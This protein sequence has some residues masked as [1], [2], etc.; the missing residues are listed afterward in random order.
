MCIHK[1]KG[2]WKVGE[3]HPVIFLGLVGTSPLTYTRIERCVKCGKRQKDR[4][5]AR[6]YSYCA[7]AAAA[8]GA[9]LVN[10]CYAGPIGFPVSLI[11]GGLLLLGAILGAILTGCTS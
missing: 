11:G 7:G 6:I 8:G 5:D 10:A 2:V 1:W 9:L 3:P 4:E